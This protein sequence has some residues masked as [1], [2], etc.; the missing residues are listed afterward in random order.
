MRK[1]L[2]TR[3]AE[4]PPVSALAFEDV[5]QRQATRA[6]I[7]GARKII[8]DV[9]PPATPIGRLGN[10]EWG[11]IVAAILFGW[12]STRA[13]QAIAENIDT[14]LAVRTN[15]FH[16]D[17]WDAGLIASVLPGIGDIHGIDWSL[18][19]GQWSREAITD[20][21]LTA[22]QLVRSAEAARDLSA[23]GITRQSNPDIVADEISILTAG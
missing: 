18:P 13:E 4:R 3:S 21:L 22:L 15:G 7:E 9:I 6:A 19:L 8:G 23:K 17:P 2:K 16:P 11:W 20:F 12:I 5:W 10:V 14:E 1:K